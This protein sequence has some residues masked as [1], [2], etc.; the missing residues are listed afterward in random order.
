VSTLQPTR[1]FDSDN[2]ETRLACHLQALVSYLHRYYLDEHIWRSKLAFSEVHIFYEYLD[3]EPI[4]V[5]VPDEL[6]Q[7]VRWSSTATYMHAGRLVHV[8]TAEIR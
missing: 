6:G 8:L 7:R 2:C 5:A 3:L 4:T 1:I